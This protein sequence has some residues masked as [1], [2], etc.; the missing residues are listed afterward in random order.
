M[1]LYLFHCSYGCEGN[2]EI[3]TTVKQRAEFVDC[4]V[5]GR[6]AHIIEHPGCSFTMDTPN[7]SFDQ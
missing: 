3:L 5:C 6:D 4:P 1:P 2:F 7:A